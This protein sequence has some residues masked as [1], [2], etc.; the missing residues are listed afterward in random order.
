MTKLVYNLI[1]SIL[2]LNSVKSYCATMQY[3]QF[4]QGNYVKSQV[5]FWYKIFNDYHSWQSVIHDSKYPELVIDVIDFKVFAKRYNR[6]IP[7]GYRF[8]LQ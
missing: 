8:L 7:Y 2:L 5:D 3:N 4:P 6:G 1:L